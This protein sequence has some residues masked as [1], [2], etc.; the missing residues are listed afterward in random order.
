MVL[1]FINLCFFSVWVCE[2]VSSKIFVCIYVVVGLKFTGNYFILIIFL[3]ININIS[4]Y[5]DH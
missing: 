2:C 1:D 5:E 4:I 3:C